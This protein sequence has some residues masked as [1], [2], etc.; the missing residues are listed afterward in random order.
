MEV[1]IATQESEND[2]RVERSYERKI[3]NMAKLRFVAQSYCLT[4]HTLAI[5]G[6]IQVT[7]GRSSM[8]SE[9]YESSR[10]VQVLSVLN[11]LSAQSGGVTRVAMARA[12]MLSESGCRSL[13]ATAEY[14]PL[15]L[16]S[17]YLLRQDGRLG[18]SVNVVNF[19]YYYAIVSKA[20]E[21]IAQISDFFV[22]SDVV[23]LERKSRYVGLTGLRSSEYLD[24]NGRIFA[25]EI[26]DSE[27]QV[28]SFQ[29]DLVGRGVLNFK[30]RDEAYTHWLNEIT[31]FAD[32]TILIADASTKAKAVSKVSA[33]S[34]RKVLTLHGNHFAKPY[35]Y[36]SPV[37]V[38][39]GRILDSARFADSLVLLTNAQMKD[40]D[41]QFHDLKDV[42]VIP[43][44]VSIEPSPKALRDTRRFVVVSRLETVKNIDMIIRAFRIALEQ[45][46]ELRLDIWGHGSREKDIQ[47]LI[48]E[49]DLAE[50]VTLKGYANPVSQVFAQARGSISASVSEGFGLS[51][52]ESMSFGCPVISLSSNY[53][54]VEIVKDGVNGYLVSDEVEMAGRIV[55]LASDDEGF[56]QM[57][58]ESFKSA[59]E[60]APSVIAKKWLV[61]V[62]DLISANW[63][64]DMVKYSNKMTNQF[65][66][67]GGNII[68][69][70][71]SVD[72]LDG[73]RQIEV[74]RID[75]A[76]KWKEQ[77]CLIQAGVYDIHSI[78]RDAS[79][80]L[81]VKFA[82]GA[83]V[84]NGVIPAGSIEFR[85]SS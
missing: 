76:K 26:I 5:I 41:R 58:Q 70:S 7:H 50:H 79:N 51:I 28:V 24:A 39:S 85:F 33:S 74:M 36:G 21:D 42:R 66:S 64:V 3:K 22:R 49:N 6:A 65:S 72:D 23:E 47:E 82:Q 68:F 54:P 81:V 2:C 13:I 20:G 8:S 4:D 9:C 1:L 31:R 40:V 43:N 71:L 73:Y 12:K 27:N 57:S 56:A 19:F 32:F 80:R 34:A 35:I 75:R 48:V 84:Y 69:S 14:D 55:S 78:G 45:C 17:V 62:Q 52:L 77:A 15:L 18:Q 67:V 83:I 46:E 11:K 10:N 16:N 59:L 60:Y 63:Q 38:V 30:T 44:S 37:T 29:L 53:G 61:L 25:R